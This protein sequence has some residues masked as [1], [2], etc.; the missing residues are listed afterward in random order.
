MESGDIKDV[1]VVMIGAIVTL[2]IEV[3]RRLRFGWMDPPKKGEP[4]VPPPI[5]PDNL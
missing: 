3:I 1:I 2:G 4:T 5:D